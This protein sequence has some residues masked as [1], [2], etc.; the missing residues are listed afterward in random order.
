MYNFA[1][2]I[3][4]NIAKLKIQIH[5]QRTYNLDIGFTFPQRHRCP[6]GSPR[7]C[8][9]WPLFRTASGGLLTVNRY[10]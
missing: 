10:W 8:D 3:L 5:K 1:N 4:A 6:S 2:V 9:D 7:F